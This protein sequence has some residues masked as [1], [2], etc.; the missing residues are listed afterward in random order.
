PAPTH[1]PCFRG[2]GPRHDNRAGDTRNHVMLLDIPPGAYARGRPG[3]TDRD[4]AAEAAAR[5]A[6]AAAPGAALRGSVVL[7]QQCPLPVRRAVA[8][9]VGRRDGAAVVRAWPHTTLAARRGMGEYAR[10]R[11]PLLRP[12]TAAWS[13]PEARPVG[14]VYRH[15]GEVASWHLRHSRASASPSRP[16]PDRNTTARSPEALSFVSS[17]L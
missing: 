13:R 5:R 16:L 8:D 3:A 6:N 11:S 15:A 14:T 1:C 4:R 12:G 17:G 2:L 10:N 7:W 9:N